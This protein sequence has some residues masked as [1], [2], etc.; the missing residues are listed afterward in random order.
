MSKHDSYVSEQKEPGTVRAMVTSRPKLPRRARYIEGCL[1]SFFKSIVKCFFY[2]LMEVSKVAS[3]QKKNQPVCTVLE[4]TLPRLSRYKPI[5]DISELQMHS[6]YLPLQ[7]GITHSLCEG[8]FTITRSLSGATITHN[9][10]N[11]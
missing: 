7:L 9:K 3:G 10:T 11:I 4:N 5:D 8:M 1:S 6:V 2:V